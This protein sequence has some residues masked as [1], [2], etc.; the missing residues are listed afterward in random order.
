[1][2]PH[3]GILAV[4]VLL[5]TAGCSDDPAPVVPSGAAATITVSSEALAA[6]HDIPRQFTCDGE[7]VSPPLAWSGRPGKAWALVVDEG[8]MTD[9]A[10]ARSPRA[11]PAVLISQRF[12]RKVRDRKHRAAR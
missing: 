2:A 6:G 5:A 11:R 1:M 3:R 9:C 4:V 10:F 7:E 8:G 12:P